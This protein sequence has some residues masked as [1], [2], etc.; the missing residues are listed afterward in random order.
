MWVAY[1]ESKLAAMLFI[2]ELASRRVRAYAVNPGGADTDI[3]RDAIGVLGWMRDHRPAP[4][5]WTTQ[6]PSEAARSSIQ[7]VTTELP[8]GTYIAPRFKQFGT[9][10]ATRSLKKARDPVVGHRLWELSTEL[11]GCDWSSA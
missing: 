10:R 7:A 2:N 6:S 4:L 8:S 3:T 5:A 11:T 1:G 9:P